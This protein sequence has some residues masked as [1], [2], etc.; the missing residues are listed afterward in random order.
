MKINLFKQNKKGFFFT[1]DA[2]FAL[3]ILLSVII[4]IP[5]AHVGIA[6]E[7]YKISYLQDDMLNMMSRFKTVDINNSNINN[8]LTGIRNDPTKINLAESLNDQDSLLDTVGKIWAVGD[9]D[10][11]RS[12][13][14]FFFN[15]VTDP[16]DN[17]GI[18]FESANGRDYLFLKNDTEYEL[19]RDVVARKEFVSGIKQGQSSAGYSARAYTYTTDKTKY[20]YFG[21]YVGDGNITQQF[22]LPNTF[23]VEE[24]RIEAAIINTR[25]NLSINDNLTYPERSAS[26][27]PFHPIFISITN[28]TELAYLQ[29]GLNNISLKTSEP[30][31]R[32]YIA[33]GFILIK[34][35]TDEIEY[36]KPE[37]KYLPIIEG[38]LNI[39]DSFYV[40]GNLTNLEFSFAYSQEQNT[41]PFFRIGNTTI[42][43][44]ERLDRTGYNFVNLNNATIATALKNNGVNYNDL[45][46]V[47]IPIRIGLEETALYGGGGIADAVLVTDVSG[48]M[49]TSDVNCNVSWGRTT[50]Q[51]YAGSY[52]GAGAGDGQS[53]NDNQK[54]C[55]YR[56]LTFAPTTNISFWR[57]VRTRTNDNLTFYID[58]ILKWNL[59][60][61]YGSWQR[62]NVSYSSGF[63]GSHELRWC[64]EKDASQTQYD[65]RVYIDNINVTNSSD[66]LFNETFEN[67]LTGWSLSN[68]SGKCGRLDVAKNVDSIFVD[69][70]LNATGSH[71]GLTSYNTYMSDVEIQDLTDNATLLKNE[72]NAY[73]SGGSTCISCGILNA[74]KILDTVPEGRFRA[75][76]MMS[77][78]R[79]NKMIDGTGPGDDGAGSGYSS[80]S[81]GE[82]T[83]KACEAR[84]ETNN[85]TM[86]AVG[87]GSAADIDQVKRI[88]CW[89]CSA[90]DPTYG[91][92][93][94][95]NMS[96]KPPPNSPCWIQNITLRNG[97]V[98]T[99][100]NSRWASS[101]DYADLE[102]IYREFAE[103]ILHLAYSNQTIEASED[104][105]SNLINGSAN[106]DYELDLGEYG[107]ILG[108]LDQS[109]PLSVFGDFI[110]YETSGFNPSTREVNFSFTRGSPFEVSVL[111][112][113]GPLWT[114]TVNINNNGTV[115]VDAYS[116]DA[117]GRAYGPLGDPFKINILPHDVA[118]SGNKNTVTLTLG[119]NSSDQ[120][121]PSESS[122]IIYT[123]IIPPTFS[124]SPPVAS[125]DGCNWTI[126]YQNENNPNQAAGNLTIAIPSTYSGSEICNYTNSTITIADP[127]D[128]YQLA[129]LNLLKDSLDVNPENGMVDIQLGADVKINAVLVSGIPFLGFTDA[130]ALSWR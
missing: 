58:N 74:T 33:G 98:T 23:N 15:E 54:I 124:Y 51:K 30:D 87:F 24:I 105:F 118:K 77:D 43:R 39:Y 108:G 46:K 60:G 52:S 106:I 22:E 95:S 56:N 28:Q 116:I 102:R 101:N 86:F 10:D 122:K 68:A 61:N 64:Y 129:V 9:I 1:L 103:E 29:G 104:V 91:S 123:L 97:T 37:K 57:R 71:V 44:D 11:S 83:N 79:A 75:M 84:N 70:I 96:A 12:I 49:G 20:I 69:T 127:Q 55:I 121:P 13:T 94:N 62:I 27:D 38:T 36:F 5:Y 18:F 6:P 14:S 31:T 67:G 100:L 115:S 99:C 110:T 82:A 65:D 88:A 66:V 107:D 76:L 73:S 45:S 41:T 4:F 59:S 40:P 63:S 90:Y 89:N 26:T 48:S 85:I 34:Y 8:N 72:I 113:S 3:V 112:Y 117:W 7:K 81:G 19:A 114:R 35:K 53:L 125:R 92:C 126:E 109:M 50:D 17:V 128:A 25:F 80:P 120:I 32:I 78:G 130:V 2:L 21:G 119:A 42:W 16:K 47:T 111:S 93:S